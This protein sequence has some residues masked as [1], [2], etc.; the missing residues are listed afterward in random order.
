MKIN[1]FKRAIKAG[2]KQ[3][4]LWVSNPDP[5][6]T[7]IVAGAGYD[8]AVCDMEHA[9]NSYAQVGRQLQA[10]AGSE[11]TPLVRPIWNDPLEVKQLMDLG[12]PG[13]IF[14][15]VQSVNEAEAAV[16]S[17][18]YPPK[19]IR[20]SAGVVRASNYGRDSDYKKSVEAET[21]IILQIESASALQQAQEISDVE[22]VDGI[23]FG[24]ADISADMGYGGDPSE[25]EVWQ[26]VMPIAKALI[27]RG[28]PVGTLTLNPQQAKLLLAEGFTF[29][30]CGLDTALLAQSADALLANIKGGS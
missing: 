28:V 19:G 14:P 5:L 29:V 2:Q 16:A 26:A 8:W 9:P 1:Q 20:G 22:G 6:N 27:A 10:F 25:A 21:A 24:P 3:V 11:T 4:G 18:Q 30:A 7:E 23:F 15:M 17:T 13:I 12:A